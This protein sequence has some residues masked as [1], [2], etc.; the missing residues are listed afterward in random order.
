MMLTFM[1]CSHLTSAFV[2]AS[3]SP[4]KFKGPFTLVST[5]A[6]ASNCNIVSM[7]CC[8]KCKRI[9]K[10][11]KLYISH[12]LHLTQIMQKMQSVNG[13]LYCIN[14]N[15]NTQMQRMSLNQFLT[16][17]IDVMLNIDVN[18]NKNVKCEHTMAD[19][20]TDKHIHVFPILYLKLD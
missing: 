10:E 17:Y 6:F 1:L 8:V 19:D 5:F 15:A 18:A 7:G 11:P 16:I 20:I 13:P 4:S 3:M 2:F 14:G 12:S 9:G